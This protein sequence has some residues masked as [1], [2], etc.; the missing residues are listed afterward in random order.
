MHDFLADGQA[1][2]GAF[3]LFPRMETLKRQE[4]AVEIFFVEADTVV[5]N[6]DLRKASGK[7][8]AGNDDPWGEIMSMVFQGVRQ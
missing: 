4:D 5:R 6:R 3:I 1:D 7:L 8:L 2:A